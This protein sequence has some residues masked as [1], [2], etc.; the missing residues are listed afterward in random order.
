MA[1]L[2]PLLPNTRQGQILR[3]W[4]CCY[5]LESKGAFLFETVYEKLLLTVFGKSG[6][7]E[8][9][10]FLWEETGV[11]V[12]FY[13]NFDRVLLAEESLWFGGQSRDEVYRSVLKQALTIKARPW[14]A[15]QRVMVSYL[16][17]QGK[18]PRAFQLLRWNRSI[19]LPGGR[20]TIAQGQI[21]RSAN[22]VTT[23]A[24]GYRFIADMSTEAACSNM[25]GGP[26]ESPF[27]KWYAS[28]LQNWLE[29][30]YKRL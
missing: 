8:V 13:S 9:A 12:D 29:G 1:I 18:L 15:R 16:P 2:R 26:S 28:D 25:P 20:A 5:D 4:D 10:R 17:F 3:D 21:Y 19:S 24:P 30:R 22:R 11:F 7:G 23:F 14:K 6:L 27:S